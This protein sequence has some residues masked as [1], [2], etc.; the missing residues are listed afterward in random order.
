MAVLMMAGNTMLMPGSWFNQGEPLPALIALELGSASPG[1]LHYQALFA[2][3]LV[4]MMVVI[5]VNLFINRLLGPDEK[6]VK[7]F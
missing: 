1:T 3:G 6:G 4:L 2:A 5:L 7:P